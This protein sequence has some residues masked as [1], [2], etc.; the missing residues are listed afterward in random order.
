M[1]CSEAFCCT[2][3]A[4]EV[5][6]IE[7]YKPTIILHIPRASSAWRKSR[8]TREAKEEK[9]SRDYNSCNSSVHL[10]HPPWP[11]VR[12]LIV[13]QVSIVALSFQ[14]QR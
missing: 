5:E 6:Q 9:S 2:A 14:N 11:R 1:I 12:F 3:D 4:M 7:M 8:H 13:T 10:H